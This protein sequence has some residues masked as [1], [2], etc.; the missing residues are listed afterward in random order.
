MDSFVT[1][2]K[3]SAVK[4]KFLDENISLRFIAYWSMEGQSLPNTKTSHR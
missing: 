2:D 3:V 1:E 4:P